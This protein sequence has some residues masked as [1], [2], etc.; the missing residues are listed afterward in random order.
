MNLTHQSHWHI[1]L[2]W[3]LPVIGRWAEV[4]CPSK[5]VVHIAVYLHLGSVPKMHVFF[6]PYSTM[7]SVLH[8]LTTYCR[9]TKQP[10]KANHARRLELQTNHPTCPLQHSGSMSF[11]GNWLIN[12]SLMK[13]KN[14]QC[15]STRAAP[16][17]SNIKS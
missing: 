5:A 16:K 2:L 6:D 7:Y 3:M 15:W 12:C 17:H 10:R 9:S 13:P 4:A 11:F 1:F 8:E 14:D